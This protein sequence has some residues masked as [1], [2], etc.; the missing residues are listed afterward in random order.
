MWIVTDSVIDP[1]TGTIFSWITS[2]NK[3]NVIIWHSG[4]I[5]FTPGETIVSLCG[6]ISTTKAPGIYTIYHTFTYNPTFWSMLLSNLKCPK[7]NKIYST[8]PKTCRVI[9]CSR[10]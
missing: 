8:C 10:K 5:D 4:G 1:T 7:N 9:C 2:E 6:G 3:M